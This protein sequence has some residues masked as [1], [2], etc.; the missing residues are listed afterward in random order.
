MANLSNVKTTKSGMKRITVEISKPGTSTKIFKDIEKILA[1]E[2]E[3]VI[4]QRAIQAAHFIRDEIANNAPRRLYR[5]ILLGEPLER[6]YNK[7]SGY[8][9]KLDAGAQFEFVLKLSTNRFGK[10]KYSGWNPMWGLLNSNYGRRGFSVAGDSK[11]PV[12]DTEGRRRKGTKY[13]HPKYG[14][15]YENRYKNTKVVMVDRVGPVTGT[16]WIEQAVES[17]RRKINNILGGKKDY[18][19]KLKMKR[20]W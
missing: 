19:K 17:G 5:E 6:F 18:T 15:G 16:N 12:P 14:Y 4:R 20:F 2:R 13:H 8:D 11:I 9:V 10:N 3:K 7:N 1:Q